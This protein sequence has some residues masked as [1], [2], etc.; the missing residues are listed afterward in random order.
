MTKRPAETVAGTGGLAGVIVAVTQ[1]NWLAVV[2]ACVGFV[3][4]AVTFVV[5]HGGVRGIFRSVWGK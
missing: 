1:H 2:V 3:P 4:A 5:A